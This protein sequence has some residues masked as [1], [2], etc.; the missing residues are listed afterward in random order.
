MDLFNKLKNSIYQTVKIEDLN[1]RL[2]RTEIGV[3]FGHDDRY[4]GYRGIM[5][6]KTL[7]AEEVCNVTVVR[8]D[9][10]AWTDSDFRIVVRKCGT[11]LYTILRFEEQDSDPELKEIVR[12]MKRNRTFNGVIKK[13][14]KLSQDDYNIES[15]IASHIVALKYEN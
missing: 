13:K 7:L 9:S 11:H 14:A 1:V 12:K 8:F 3:I 4:K 10:R 15:I 6:F 2:K 5:T